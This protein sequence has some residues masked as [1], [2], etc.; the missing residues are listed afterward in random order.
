M[1]RETEAEGTLRP[2]DNEGW[3]VIHNA[4]FDVVMP[5]LS[6][7]GF[8]VLCVAIR[9]TLGW[10]DPADRSKRKKWDHIPY[11]TF[12]EKS[13]IASRET[14]KRALDECLERDFLIRRQPLGQSGEPR[15]IR[16]QPYFEYALNVEYELPTKAGDRTG[17][18]TVPVTGTETVP[19]RPPT[20]TETVPP[21]RNIQNKSSNGDDASTDEQQEA[22]DLLIN[23]NISPSMARRLV[24]EMKRSLE[25]VNAW[26]HSAQN[27]KGL[28][29]PPG[30]VVAQLLEG[31]PPPSNGK[32][33]EQAAREDRLRYRE[34]GG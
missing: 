34:W 12:L 7:N 4:V 20:G 14:L 30:Y 16:G 26:I 28:R 27:E 23:F 21:K 29:N 15:E 11:S 2:F 10:V 6:P 8:K 32:D 13:G 22:I 24:F 31:N 33:P 25:D 1:T 19:M 17:T 18:E 9:Q 5:S 3:F